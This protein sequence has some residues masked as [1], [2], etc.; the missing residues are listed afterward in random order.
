MIAKP[1]R[2]R[3][4]YAAMSAFI[5]WHTAAMVLAPAPG[6]SG[7]VQSVRAVF[8]PY[9]TLL[10]LD[11]QWDFFA[12]NVGKGSLLRYVIRDA[13]GEGH[14]FVPLQRWS[15]VHPSYIWFHD[16]Y[17][18]VLDHPE[19]YGEAF[20]KLL[21]KEHAA[22]NPVSVVL[23]DVEEQDFSPEDLLDGKHPLDPEFV[24]IT[25]VKNVRC[26]DP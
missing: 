5:I 6:N 19:E 25:P 2:E 12:P 21:C 14:A 9:L 7:L 23:Q 8:D 16:W 20:A 15:W 4:A 26:S 24:K 1:W 17:D 18:T 11:N 10:R 3:L 22:L 13:A